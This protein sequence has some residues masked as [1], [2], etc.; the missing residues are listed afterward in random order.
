MRLW[1]FGAGSRVWRCSSAADLGLWSAR[2]PTGSGYK[3]KKSSA[4]SL[5]FFFPERLIYLDIFGYFEKDCAPTR[6]RAGQPW[7][8][9]CGDIILEFCLSP[10]KWTCAGRSSWSPSTGTRQIPSKWST[11]RADRW[12]TQR[13]GVNALP[14]CFFGG[15]DSATDS[16]EKS[17]ER[18]A[19]SYAQ[20]KT[21]EHLVVF[22]QHRLDS[23]AHTERDKEL[24]GF[25]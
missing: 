8:T 12:P 21:G 2:I 7:G 18:S 6:R 25:A 1:F 10:S 13:R 23:S 14:V 15:D 22:S 4:P 11:R 19:C 16:V 17:I 5:F 20:N 3:V 9:R 24:S